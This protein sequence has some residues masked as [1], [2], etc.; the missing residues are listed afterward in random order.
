MLTRRHFQPIKSTLYQPIKSLSCEHQFESRPKELPFE[1]QHGKYVVM[2]KNTE[3]MRT[4]DL[5]SDL[6][7][8]ILLKLTSASVNYNPDLSVEHVY[9]VKLL[10]VFS[11]DTVIDFIYF[12]DIRLSSM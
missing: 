7:S 10:F 2:V 1:F 5:F 9:Y 8:E 6:V 4:F 12:S 11:S 3:S